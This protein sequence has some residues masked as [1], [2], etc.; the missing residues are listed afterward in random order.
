MN[1]YIKTIEDE[2]EGLR[3][4]MSKEK[5][6]SGQLENFSEKLHLKLLEQKAKTSSLMQ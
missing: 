2:I 4:L 6:H 5:K 1:K 3:S